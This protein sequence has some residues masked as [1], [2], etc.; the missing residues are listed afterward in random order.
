MSDIHSDDHGFPLANYSELSRIQSL[1]NA[2]GLQVEFEGHIPKILVLALLLHELRSDTAHSVDAS[3]C[4]SH[5]LNAIVYRHIIV[6]HDTEYE[7][8]TVVGGGVHFS[9]DVL[10][11]TVI[12]S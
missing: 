6:W 3:F 8:W 1:I 7:S 5:G 9:K 4:V 10:D 12:S 11:Q 2:T